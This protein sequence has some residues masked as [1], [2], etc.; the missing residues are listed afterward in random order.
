MAPMTITAAVDGSSLGNPGPA[1]WAWVIDADHWDAGGWPQGTNNIGELTAFLELVK[2]TEA[3]GRAHE[4][5]H[6][7][8][9]SQYVINTVTKWRHGWKRNGWRKS[10]RQPIK[11]LDLIQEIDRAVEGRD[12]TFE[13]VKGHAGHE[14]NEMADTLARSCAQAYKEGR[15]PT[16]GPGLPVASGVEAATSADSKA[17]GARGFAAP[18]GPRAAPAPEDEG[19]LF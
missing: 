6:I 18:I 8:A 4:P 1:G 19:T 17:V 16:S 7:L 10:D 11:N 13:W 5:L 2:A 14:L 12:I 3:A 9:D 15:T